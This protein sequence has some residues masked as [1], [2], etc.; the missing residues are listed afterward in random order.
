MRTSYAGINYGRGIANVDSKTGIRFGV[1]SSN[2]M[3]Y[4]NDDFEP[5]YACEDCNDN[6]DCD[7]EPLS[8]FCDRE[9]L[10]AECP[11]DTYEITI[12]HSKY[13]TYA[14]FCSPCYPGACNLNA[15]LDFKNENNRAYCFGP[16][17]FDKDDP[18]NQAP[19]PIFEV[20]TGKRVG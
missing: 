5:Y 10:K 19:Y 6:E 7:C 15:P 12:Y 1:I 9:D 14:Q 3:Q 11:T 2:T 20:T 8:Y 13:F 16:E 4:F 18:H 17:W